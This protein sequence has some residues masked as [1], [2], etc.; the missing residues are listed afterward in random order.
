MTA[1]HGGRLV[2]RSL[3]AAGAQTVF[4]LCGDHINAIFEG[5]ADEGV[6]LIDTRD[7]RGA[8]HMAEGWSL[9]TRQPGVAIVTGG[10]GSPHA[11]TP[12]ADAARRG[13]GG[14]AGGGGEEPHPPRGVGEGLPAGHRPDGVRAAAV[15]LVED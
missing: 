7:E 1:M 10:P 11:L 2:A 6:R 15:G 4:G 9:A 5:C 14:Q 8:A 12:L 3:K 13:A